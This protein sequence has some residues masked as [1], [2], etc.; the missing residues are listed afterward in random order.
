MIPSRRLP[1]LQALKLGGHRLWP[2][3]QLLM[4]ASG[5]L[6]PSGAGGN[7]EPAGWIVDLELLAVGET[8]T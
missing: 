4:P 7:R 6:L 2:T 8:V 1:P 3:L 5:A